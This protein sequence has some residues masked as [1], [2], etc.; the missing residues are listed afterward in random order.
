[1]DIKYKNIDLC[2]GMFNKLPDIA[3]IMG[4]NFKTSKECLNSLKCNHRC[5]TV[6]DG[7]ESA[8]LS[9]ALYECIRD[10]TVGSP[11]EISKSRISH[12]SCDALRGHFLMTWNT[13][14]TGSMLRK[15]IGLAL[16]CM[17]PH[18]LYSKY[19]ENCKLLG[20]KPDRSVFN[21]LANEMSNEI[22]K[23]IKIAVVGRIKTDKNK[24]KDILEKAEKKIPQHH[25]EKSTSPVPKYEKY[26]TDY[27]FIKV[28]GV[29]SIAVADYIL[30]K[31][32]GMSLD[33]FD[34]KIVIYNKAWK[35]KE[36]VLSKHD[37]IKD[38][39]RQKYEKLGEDFHLIFAYLAI[40][41]NLS[42]CCTITSI[43][44]NKLKP[45]GMSDMIKNGI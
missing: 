30:G 17:A 1:M 40:T 18:K 5:E 42:D 26:E 31:S 3:V 9:Y 22:K 36:T 28:T 45:A 23:H 12:I 35:G 8:C 10:K 32:G 33:V 34:D 6:Y 43:L 44:K 11:L 19:A 29:S 14:G 25:T 21:T 7:A 24:L 15:T 20:C 41:K 2:V 39:V 16:S 38:Y 4:I 13:Q 27:P 37:R